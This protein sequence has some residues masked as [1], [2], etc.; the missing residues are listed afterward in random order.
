MKTFPIITI[1]NPLLKQV[2]ANVEEITEGTKSL[3][4][5][6]KTTLICSFEMCRHSC[7]SS[8]NIQTYYWCRSFSE[9]KRA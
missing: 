8:R 6:L 5:N 9:F 2:S 3:I 4:K 1:S 7:C